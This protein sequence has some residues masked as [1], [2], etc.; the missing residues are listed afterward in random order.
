MELGVLVGHSPIGVPNP[1]QPSS[2]PPLPAGSSACRS[3]S[4]AAVI[5]CSERSDAAPA[6]NLIEAA[7]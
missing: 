2:R 5:A 4:A 3:P 6:I 1:L 7:T